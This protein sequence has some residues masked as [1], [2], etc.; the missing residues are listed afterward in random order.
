[1]PIFLPDLAIGA[2]HAPIA[3]VVWRQ[4]MTAEAPE[5]DSPSVSNHF[6][7]FKLTYNSQGSRPPR[8]FARSPLVI[9]GAVCYGQMVRGM[10]FYAGES[11]LPTC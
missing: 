5:C 4:S 11:R 2:S 9:N 3:G 6:Y 7:N 8:Q 1:M 10:R